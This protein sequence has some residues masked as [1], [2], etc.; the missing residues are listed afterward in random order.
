MQLG[1]QFVQMQLGMQFLGVS[2]TV[3][4]WHVSD[5]EGSHVDF[6]NMMA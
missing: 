6:K 1:M 2:V 3:W 4:K 5:H